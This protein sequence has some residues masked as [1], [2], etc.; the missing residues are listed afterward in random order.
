MGPLFCFRVP[1]RGQELL[2]AKVAEAMAEDAKNV[3][4]VL[5]EEK[6]GAQVN[7]SVLQH[8]QLKKLNP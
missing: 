5:T 4:Q 8:T 7:L 3:S 2:T 6:T 1:S